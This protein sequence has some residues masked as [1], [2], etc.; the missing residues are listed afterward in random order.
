MSFKKKLVLGGAMLGATIGSASA[1]SYISD[2]LTTN[3][4]DTL[5]SATT[6]IGDV[7]DFIPEL[8]P[9]AVIGL[10]MYIILKFGSQLGDLLGR[11]TDMARFKK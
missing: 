7:V 3:I 6:L 11:F 10:V 2:T 4:G 9:L 5:D 1:T 8:I